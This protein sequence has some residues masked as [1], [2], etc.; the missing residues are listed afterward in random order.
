[1]QRLTPASGWSALV[2]TSALVAMP[3]VAQQA[4]VYKWTDE[5]GVPHY[6]DQPP[7]NAES[8]ALPIRYRRPDRS[9]VQAKL[10]TNETRQAA[11]DLREEQEEAGE[12]T[13]A[14]QREKDLAER[15]ATCKQ[16]RERVTTYNQ[17]QKLYKPGPNGDRIYLTDE[18]LDAERADA[19][20]V[21]EEWCSDE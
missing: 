12:A 13:A 1:M 7:V 19:Q 4:T 11:E 8:E 20:R 17:V 5:Q 15:A 2:L 6:S 10:K 21:M 9:A 14:T 3:A 16:A 18:E